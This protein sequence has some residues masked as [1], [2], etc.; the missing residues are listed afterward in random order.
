MY[1]E[2]EQKNLTREW[3]RD[4]VDVH[5][6][7]GPDVLHRPFDDEKVAIAARGAGMEAILIKN[8]VAYL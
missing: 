4:A 6:H 3:T 2:D 8:H 5:I 7:S 1:N